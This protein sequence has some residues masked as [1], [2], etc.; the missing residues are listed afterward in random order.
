ME[1]LPQIQTI[2]DEFSAPIS[3]VIEAP[4]VSVTSVNGMTGDVV[5]EVK[6]S[7]FEPNHYY[8]Q[9]TAVIYEGSLY[10]AKEDFTS[11]SSFNLD[12]WNFPKF[13]QVQANW[14]EEDASSNAYIKNKPTK[15]SEFTNDLNLISEDDVDE[16]VTTRIEPLEKS[17]SE[18]ETNLTAE[19]ET[20]KS[21]IVNLNKQIS[22]IDDEVDGQ[23]T[24]IG[25]ITSSISEIE[26]GITSLKT[27]GSVVRLGTESVGSQSQPIYLN[28]GNPAVCKVGGWNGLVGTSNTG[29]T[30]VGANLHF[31]N[32]A[33]DTSG[34]ISSS[35]N[36]LVLSNP[37]YIISSSTENTILTAKDGWLLIGSATVSSPKAS[38]HYVAVPTQYRG[39]PWEYKVLISHEIIKANSQSNIN[40]AWLDMDGAS[41]PYISA[42]SGSRNDTTIQFSGSNVQFF[43]WE[44]YNYVS[45]D[46]C[47][48]EV[49]VS[50]SNGQ[51]HMWTGTGTCGGICNG[52]GSTLQIGSRSGTNSAITFFNMNLA[53]YTYGSWA[54]GTHLEVFAR[55]SDW[56]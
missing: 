43:G 55:R 26:Q 3:T 41:S 46:A 9:G 50:S 37:A 35:L 15:L 45:G 2:I 51:L 11:G 25:S 16:I 7:N 49:Y 20:N 47:T 30:N 19:I 48:A 22:D 27:D 39:Y 24:V 10:Y 52:T 23:A 42:I 40:T 53:D 18:V 38:Q 4:W 13:V 5:V 8:P 54:V 33:G 44:W 1:T 14:A 56:S 21:S 32:D 34:T 36:G 17:I 28:E 6:L 31:V 12:D 29:V